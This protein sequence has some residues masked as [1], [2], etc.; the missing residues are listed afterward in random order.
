MKKWIGLANWGTKK[1]LA[2]DYLTKLVDK[3]IL[4]RDGSVMMSVQV[5]GLLFETEIRLNAQATT[6]EVHCGHLW[7]PFRALSPCC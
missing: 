6:R 4:L 1:E 7:I 2:T 5:P 3:G